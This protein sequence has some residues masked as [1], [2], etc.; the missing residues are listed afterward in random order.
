MEEFMT[1]KNLQILEYRLIF[2]LTQLFFY[3]LDRAREGFGAERPEISNL[4]ICFKN[5]IYN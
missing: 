4:L 5:C 3:I 1:S 2:L